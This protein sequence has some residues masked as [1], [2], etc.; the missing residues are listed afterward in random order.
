MFTDCDRSSFPQL[1]DWEATVESWWQ[2][3]CWGMQQKWDREQ[4]VWS[5]SSV[6]KFWWHQEGCVLVVNSEVNCC[7]GLHKKWAVLSRFCVATWHLPEE[8][9]NPHGRSGPVT[10]ICRS[11]LLPRGPCSFQTHRHITNLSD[12]RNET[13]ARRFA[14]CTRSSF[15]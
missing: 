7:G 9:G 6:T 14:S 5:C 3:D 8:R 10:E 1:Q 13:D 12:C 11:K 15:W 4:L 2:A